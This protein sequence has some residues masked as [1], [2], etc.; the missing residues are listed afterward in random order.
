MTNIH[1]GFYHVLFNITHYKPFIVK[2]TQ[3]LYQ[4]NSLNWDVN[5]K[6]KKSIYLFSPFVGKLLDSLITK[7]NNSVTVNKYYS[8]IHNS[9]QEGINSQ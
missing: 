6:K 8:W 5:S 4:G 1:N 3:S 7:C 2:Q 9:D